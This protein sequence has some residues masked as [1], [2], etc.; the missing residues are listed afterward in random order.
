[1]NALPILREILQ[2]LKDFY[3]KGETHTIY[4]N[5]IPL[6]PEDRELILD[7]LGEGKVRITYRSETQPAEWRETGIYG[8]WIGVIFNRD[9]KPILEIIEITDFPRLVA[10]Q[11]E[12]IAE[13]IKVLEERLRPY[14]T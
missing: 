5:K 6:T 9:K 3:E 1:M 14:N 10:S 8:V 7:V 4:I 2:A 13:S 12:D 11:R